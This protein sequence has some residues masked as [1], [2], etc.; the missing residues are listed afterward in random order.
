MDAKQFVEII[1]NQ[2]HTHSDE[3]YLQQLER[4]GI[5][6]I[7]AFGVRMPIVKSIAK[8]HKNQ[9][10]LALSLF[11]TPWHE[12]QIMATMIAD[13]SKLTREEAIIWISKIKTWDLCDQMCTNLLWKTSFAE[14]LAFEYC[15]KKSEFEKRAGF[16][17]LTC[18]TIHN[19]KKTNDELRKY[20]P[21]IISK[22]DDDR[23]FVKK[24]VNWLL[25]TIGKKN[26]VLFYEAIAAAEELLKLEHKSAH[27]IAKDALQEFIKVGIKKAW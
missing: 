10:K 23:N 5:Q 8:A 16:V 21:Y 6:N 2:L 11:N 3:G 26:S 4:F 15:S 13:P 14:E 22:A 12:A 19:K 18:I 24:A 17:L 20:L 25:R 27:W 7:D 9:H 1:I